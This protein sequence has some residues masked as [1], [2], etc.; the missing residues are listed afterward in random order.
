MNDINTKKKL[1]RWATFFGVSGFIL[2]LL[3]VGTDD[4]REFAT[5]TERAKMNIASQ[6]TTNTMT[7]TGMA[8]ML[9]AIALLRKRDNM[10]KQR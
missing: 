7:F 10:D 1:T 6:K 2:A 9:G 8:S 5:P 3:G 4:A